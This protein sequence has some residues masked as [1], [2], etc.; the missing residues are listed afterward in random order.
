MHS[1]PHESRLV[2]LLSD[3]NVSDVEVSQS[4]FSERFGQLVDLSGSITLSGML[5]ELSAVSF[6]PTGISTKAI[7]DEFLRVRTAL[8]H[9]IAKS[10]VPS[11]G[12]LPTPAKFHS[13]CK[14]TG[15]YTATRSES[16]KNHAAAYEPY[17]NFYMARQGDLA[18]KIQ[19]LRAHIRDSIS[20]LS[21]ELAQLSSLDTGLGDVLSVRTRELFAVVPKL[22]GTRFGRLLHE[23]WQE[24]PSKPV[25]SDLE[26]WMKPGGW[27]SKFCGEMRELLL[28]EIEIR[29][30]PVLG[31][32][33]ALPIAATVNR[34]INERT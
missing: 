20:G 13:H 16:P 29:L 6:Q 18:V 7:K 26:P 14:L 19:H 11:V 3:L 33:D 25:A 28:A 15:V 12:R 1:F 21:P 27:I 4:H 30:Q 34:T 2:R 9:S 22:L 5:G 8:V 23:H 10:F 31:M 17:R 24:L 32:I